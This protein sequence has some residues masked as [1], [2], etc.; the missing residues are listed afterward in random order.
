MEKKRLKNVHQIRSEKEAKAYLH[1][2]RTRIL[3]FL[4]KQPMTVSQIAD[5]LK[6]HPANL[7]HHFKKLQ[8][9]DLIQL[10]EERDT[11]RVV[12]KYYRSIAH[13][14]EMRQEI[15]S[16]EAAGSHALQALQQDMAA[17]AAAL[18][19]DAKNL[20]CLIASAQLTE[21]GFALFQKKL[22]KLMAEFRRETRDSEQSGQYY[23]LNLSLY[24]RNPDSFISDDL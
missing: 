20:I 7:T 12:E 17:A 19:S 21:A 22:E 1:P 15:F 5:I 8:E 6:V 14:F 10:V 24:P 11:G 9:A 16:M 3:Q 13:S 2:V 23:S 18:P 4:K